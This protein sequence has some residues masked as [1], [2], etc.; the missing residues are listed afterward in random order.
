MWKMHETTHITS[1]VVGKDKLKG[2]V[3]S[4]S[5]HSTTCYI[6]KPSIAWEYFPISPVDTSWS[7]VWVH[8]GFG[9]GR[10]A[11]D[12]H[13][14]MRKLWDVRKPLTGNGSHL[15]DGRCLMQLMCCLRESW[16][17]VW[18]RANVELSQLRLLFPRLLFATSWRHALRSH[19][20]PR[21]PLI[22]P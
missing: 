20:L 4:K 7:D 1:V 22:A 13:A 2:N 9:E 6:T 11:V 21:W 12:M 18:G 5:I 3:I 15:W 14:S 10:H 17:C 16:P 8:G 19:S